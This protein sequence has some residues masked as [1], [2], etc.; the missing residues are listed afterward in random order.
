MP[1]ALTK[2]KDKIAIEE[3]RDK[4]MALARLGYTTR[5][6][7]GSVGCSHDTV[8]RD[9]RARVDAQ[10]AACKD[11]QRLR[12]MILSAVEDLLRKWYPRAYSDTAALDRVL[13]MLDTRA[14][15]LGVQPPERVEHSGAVDTGPRQVVV[16]LVR[17]GKD[18]ATDDN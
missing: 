2:S 15:Y 5:Q 17:T 11:T 7:A 18:E 14:R 6:I 13:K 12:F 1:K 10:A 9:I 8:A 16:E 3:R 4:V